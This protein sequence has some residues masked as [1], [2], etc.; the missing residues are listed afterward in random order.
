VSIVKILLVDDFVPWHKVVK[1]LLEPNATLQVI[2]EA[3]SGLE[4]VGKVLGL[5]PDLVL[6]DI[7]L[8][9]MNGIEVARHIFRVAPGTKIVFVTENTD[10]AVMKAALSTG[11]CGYVVKSD[12]VR[13]LLPAIEAV[14]VG[15]QFIGLESE[16]D[17]SIATAN[18][19]EPS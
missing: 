6:L 17:S 8:P 18:N 9:V 2:G 5:Q 16:D 3:T 1:S 15:R 14:A 12:A 13:Q 11:A 7:G 10:R 4:A 19:S